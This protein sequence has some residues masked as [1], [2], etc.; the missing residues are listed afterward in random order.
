MTAS[1]LQIHCLADEDDKRFLNLE[2][3]DLQ[4][5]L[6]HI[7]DPDLVESLKHGI[8]FYHEAMSKQ[9]RCL[10]FL[11]FFLNRLVRHNAWYTYS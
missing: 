6:D 9:A 5:H 1:D 11:S 2:E 8:G 4:V 7:T 3:K 10:F